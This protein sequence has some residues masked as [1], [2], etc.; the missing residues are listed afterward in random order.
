MVKGIAMM[1]CDSE[2]TSRC[3]E[4]LR[5]AEAHVDRPAELGRLEITVTPAG[6]LDAEAIARFRDL[7]VD[8]IV[9]LAL[10]G[11]ADQRIEFVET[12]ATLARPSA[13]D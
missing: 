9:P 11:S 3:L 6:V 4:G 2:T 13:H 10:G 12:T 5:E 8:R 7:G 1:K